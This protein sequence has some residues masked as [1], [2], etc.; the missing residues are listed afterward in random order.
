MTIVKNET[1]IFVLTFTLGTRLKIISVFS[2]RNLRCRY[3]PNVTGN[4]LTLFHKLCSHFNFSIKKRSFS[5][6]FS[7][8]KIKIIAE[9]SA[10]FVIGK[11]FENQYTF[12]FE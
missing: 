2:V 5:H 9:N 8:L 7:S 3:V 12:E 10:Q 4:L 1:L 11:Q 6:K